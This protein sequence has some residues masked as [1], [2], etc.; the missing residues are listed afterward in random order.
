M[1]PTTATMA[2]PAAERQVPVVN[3]FTILVATVNGTGS[4]TANNTLIRTIMGMGVPVSGKN[5]FP[6]NIQGLPTWYSIRVCEA[7]WTGFRRNPDV[8][9]AMNAATA[10]EDVQRCLPGAAVIY[11]APLALDKQRK[12]VRYYPVPFTKIVKGVCDKPALWKLVQNMIYV[13][14]AAELLGLD[15]GQI[16]KAL[17]KAFAT[18]AKALAMNWSAVKVGHEY[19]QQNFPEKPVVRVETRDLTAGK[20]LIDGNSAAALGAVL[21]G[22]TVLTWYPITPSSSL[23]EAA[24]EYF[25]KFRKTPDGKNTFAVVQAEDELAAIGMCIGAGWAGARSFTSTSGP[26]ISLMSEF[27]GLGYYAEVPCVIVNV[28]RTGPSTGLPTRTMQG[29][30]LSTAYLSHGDTKHPMYLPATPQE[31]YEFTLA[32]FELAEFAQTPVFVLSDL[33]LGMNNW[34]VDPFTYPE[35]PISRGKVL[36]PE[37]FQELRATWG[38]YADL[39]GDGVP[40][41]TLPGTEA[42]GMAF[43]TRGS[44]H[45]DKARYTEDG[46]VY[47]QNMDR[48]L[49]KF[50]TIRARMPR[51]V[52]SPA[53]RPT[54]VGLLAFGTTHFAIEETRD[55]LR[56][57]GVEVDYLRVRAFPFADEVRAFLASHDHVYVVEQNRDAQMASMLRIDYPEHG[58]KLRSVLRYDGLPADAREL[59]DEIARKEKQS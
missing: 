29:D 4:Q 46:G 36:T 34:M 37:K 42:D 20:V 51:P 23:A 48:L 59:T 19:A 24:T 40:W 39:D 12:D 25:H 6:S 53:S 49:R 13:G 18:K 50:E 11:D 3:D 10:L 44:G 56:R 30:L 7:G 57:L 21:A 47:A 26:G 33:D 5:I 28:Q 32:A 52:L 54:P 38:R 2:E 9:I 14:V 15:L 35:E 8:L 22:A 27:V 16:E 41:R 58:T 45:D 17:K 43:F 55:Q 1:T 31:A